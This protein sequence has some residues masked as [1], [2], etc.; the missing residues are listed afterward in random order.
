MSLL[1]VLLG[2][3]QSETPREAEIIKAP[4]GYPGAKSRSVK[5]LLPHL[6][7]KKAFI[8]VCGGTGAVLFGRKPSDLEVFNERHS[9]IT[10]FYRCLRDIT[11]YH[12]LVERLHMVP[13]C[14]REEFQWARDSWEEQ[15]HTDVERAARWY[16][17]AVH[18]F[19]Q[20]GWHFG[21]VV[22]GRSQAEKYKN[23]FSLFPAIHARLEGVQIENLDWRIILNDYK[24]GGRNVI[25]YIDPPYWNTGGNYLH[26][27]EK[28][29][30][31]ELCERILDLNGGYVILSGY[32]APDHP[33]NLSRVPWT[34]KYSWEVRTSMAG[35]AFTESNNL[36]AFEGTVQRE[37]ATETIW[38]YDGKST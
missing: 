22:Q 37:K 15:H 6:P 8:D 1:D 12:A 23:N 31:T 7:Y 34:Y 3:D 4:F 28:K 24:R 32:D 17:S 2:L 16:Y 25:W 18:S 5:E 38:V 29:D 36:A 26:E 10:A 13:S 9:G 33:Y 19:N 21:R 30:H 20:K 11:K 27:W 14:S 35:M